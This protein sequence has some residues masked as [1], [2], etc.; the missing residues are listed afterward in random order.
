MVV[1]Q[2][3]RGVNVI[4]MLAFSDNQSASHFAVVYTTLLDR[5][6][7]IPTRIESTIARTWCWL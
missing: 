4:W 2:E 3:S 7:A 6:L 1:L 5:L